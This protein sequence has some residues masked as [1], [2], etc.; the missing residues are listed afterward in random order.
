M[1]VD[2]LMYHSIS[3]AG[4]PTSIPPATFDWQ[5][6]ALAASGVPVLSLD[7]LLAPGAPERAVAIT[8]DDAFQD[9]ART[10]WPILSRHGFPA[11]V[12]VPTGR[13]G[14]V[15]DWRG[16]AEPPRPL[17]D[18]ATIRTLSAEGVTFGS[19]TVSHPDLLS[20][21]RE[22]L[23]EE[24]AASKAELEDRTGR[25][26]DHFAAPYG[27]DSAPVRA[28]VAEHYRSAAGTRLGSVGADA[29]RYDLPRIEMFYYTRPGPWQ[30]H[31]AGRGRAYLGLRRALRA[32][33]DR[34]SRPWER[35]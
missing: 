7:D 19:H 18:W 20:L 23:V 24:L 25:A 1:A 21:D 17:M 35:A 10:A 11:T 29:D 14:G 4:G 9:F 28:A 34:T 2:I 6:A 15:E 16:A 26:A 33:R 32:V 5:M 27:R 13:V 3:D 8:F 30:R 22:A 12:Y 31:L